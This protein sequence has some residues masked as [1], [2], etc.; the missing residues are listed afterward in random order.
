M[1]I[2]LL[3]AQGQLG[4][5]IQHCFA[6]N[7]SLIV[8]QSRVDITDASAVAD[9]IN[10]SRPDVVINTAAYTQVDLAET[11][12]DQAFAVNEL[13]VINLI[14]AVDDS[15]R[16]I[17]VST[18]FVF[19]GEQKTPYTPDSPTDPLGIY[20]VSKRAGEIALL[21]H[22]AS[23]VI[24]RTS[25]LYAP[26]LKNFVMTM[27]NLMESR[28]SL[29]IV[30]DQQGCPTSVLSLANVISLMAEQENAHGIYHWADQGIVSWYDFACEIQKQAY[31]LG[32]L[33][34]KIPL[35]PIKT[36]GYP[37][38]AKRPAYSA[39]DCSKTEQL[40]QIKRAPWQDELQKVLRMIQR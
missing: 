5:A 3:G 23:A 21:E 15:T 37:T 12:K 10:I 4:S 11:E 7:Q 40:L 18:D 25:W 13:G 1:N 20:G 19:N 9:C 29:N 14:K 27:L 24:L 8:P 39:L 32:L 16:I 26:W 31:A 2:L 33:T 34:D 6:G 22:H 35:N 36:E 38:P 17:H 28:D 30:N